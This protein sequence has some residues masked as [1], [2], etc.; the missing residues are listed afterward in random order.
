MDTEKAG[1]GMRVL[2]FPWLAVGHITPFFELAK[3]LSDRGFLMIHLCSTPINLSFIKNKIP[4]KYSSSIQLVELYL[5][6][7]P[8]LPPHYH[9]T[10][11]LPHHLNSTLHKALKMAEP[12]FSNIMGTIKPHLV[13]YDVQ[14]PWAAL[15][16]KSHN[17]SA[18]QFITSSS[19]MCSYAFHVYF[20][21]NA[22]FP[23]S[24]LSLRKYDRERFQKM[25][26][27]SSSNSISSSDI[28]REDKITILMST[29]REIEGNKYL[30]Y[31]SKLA[32]CK[33][34]TLGTLVQEHH[35]DEEH[36]EPLMEWLGTKEEKSTVFVSFG[37]ECFLSDRDMHELAT[38]LE[39]SKV[40]FIWVV[41]FPK[42]VNE[43]TAMTTMTTTQE[44]LLQ[45]SLPIGF[46][47][48]VGDRGRM[49]E[50]WAPQHR[51]LLHPSIGGF[52]S[53]CGW[54]STVESIEC[55][56]PIIAM[57]M[58]FDQPL[59]AKL[60][61]SLGVG[62]EVLRDDAGKFHSQDVAR[63]CDEIVNG[64][65]GESIQKNVKVMSENVRL[66]SMKEMDQAATWL[67]RICY[68]MF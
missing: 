43:T 59:N 37:S 48:R 61:A 57:P 23:F 33:I 49:M 58:Q 17:V 47:E 31:M 26:D 51:I 2:M 11:G 42:S 28:D 38:G 6:E 40:N 14:Q 16:A 7:L 44:N 64:K 55:G 20:R 10:N 22:E 34:L 60:I 1:N 41:K 9:T 8:E 67:E 62:I 18:V 27:K 65:L 5:P 63:V 66:N 21:K 12:T 15:V 3:K 32:G 29:S 52:M 39:K 50:G 13:I 68:P 30:D 36:F 54:N 25:V 45:K 4:Q 46:L 56:V 35:Q 53:H 24:E 19:A